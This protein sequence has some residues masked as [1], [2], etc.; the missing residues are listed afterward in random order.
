MKT[1]LLFILMKNNYTNSITISHLKETF[2]NIASCKGMDFGNEFKQSEGA[3]TSLLNDFI[4]KPSC[5]H[6]INKQ[7]FKALE[8]VFITCVY[9][10]ETEI[11]SLVFTSSQVQYNSMYDREVH[12]RDNVITINDA[13]CDKVMLLLL[14]HKW[15]SNFQLLRSS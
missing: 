7:T 10:W 14:L 9:Y 1:H 5:M 15:A 4:S 6:R 11:D 3:L 8:M 13:P 2:K 12:W